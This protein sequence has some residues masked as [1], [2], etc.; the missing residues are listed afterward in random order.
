MYTNLIFTSNKL[1]AINYFS[2]K[3]HIFH[4]TPPDDQINFYTHNQTQSDKVSQKVK[5]N[6]RAKHNL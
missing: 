1:K 6:G 3:V 5:Y 4:A 2:R